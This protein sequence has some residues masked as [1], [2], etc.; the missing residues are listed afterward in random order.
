MK[1]NVIFRVFFGLIIVVLG[2]VLLANNLGVISF[3][4]WDKFWGV[5]GSG[6]FLIAGLLTIISRSS[7]IWG[8][9]LCAVG[10]TIVLNTFNIVDA[11]VWAVL[12]PAVLI[13]VGL[14][15]LFKFDQPK[16]KKSADKSNNKTAVFYGEDSRPKGDYDG[17]SLSAIFGGIELDLRQANIKDG[18]VIDIFTFCGGIDITM[19]SDVVVQNEVRGFL[20]GSEDKTIP[21]AKAKKKVIVRGEC[22]LG[23]L[24]IK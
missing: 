1:N 12:W 10:A 20:G 15:I 19:P 22:I 9:L 5:F 17:G 24:D 16:S 6:L 8:I 7:W 13:G 11:S 3:N 18:T 4:D 21:D 23:G 14:S 2:G